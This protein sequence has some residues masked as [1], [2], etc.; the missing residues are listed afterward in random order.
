MRRFGVW[1]SDGEFAGGYARATSD[2]FYRGLARRPAGQMVS[3]D[4]IRKAGVGSSQRADAFGCG[5]R[6]DAG[7]ND[8]KDGMLSALP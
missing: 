6:V 2:P 1:R 4:I 7:H 3:K 8:L 5:S